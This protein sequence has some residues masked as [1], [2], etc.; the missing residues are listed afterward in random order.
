[1]APQPTVRSPH[2]EAPL[3]RFLDCHQWLALGL[4]ADPESMLSARDLATLDA[5]GA[6]FIC[7]NG[8]GPAR[9]GR[10]LHLQC[11]DRRFMAWAEEHRVRGLLLRPDRFIAARLDTG[12]DLAVLNPFVMATAATLPLAA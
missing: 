9:T 5:L 3:D 11:D 6:R 10:S 1:M 7:L 12:A 2:G 4:N 8:L